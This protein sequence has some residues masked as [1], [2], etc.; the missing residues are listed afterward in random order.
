MHSFQVTFI[1]FVECCFCAW[2]PCKRSYECSASGRHGLC[3]T[4]DH[5][6]CE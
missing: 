4:D 5:I 6:H 3:S 2:T 1:I